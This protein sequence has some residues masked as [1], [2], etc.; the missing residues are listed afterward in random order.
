[1]HYSLEVCEAFLTALRRLQ[2]GISG[3]AVVI[4]VD[5]RAGSG[6]TIFSHLLADTLGRL[7]G[8]VLR[9]RFDAF[10]L[11]GQEFEDLVAALP[12]LAVSAPAPGDYDYAWQL[13]RERLLARL[14][15]GTAADP[16]LRRLVAAC[17]ADDAAA[18]PDAAD[19]VILEGTTCLRREL[20]ASYDLSLLLRLDPQV[21]LR[22][23]LAREQ[24]QGADYFVNIWRPL[25]ARYFEEH[26]PEAAADFV[27]D[28]LLARSAFLLSTGV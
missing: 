19:W 18:D 22:Q 2:A 20:R 16:E 21:C 26:Q 3:R 27:I 10:W 28:T 11:F 7:G 9:L 4:G 15:A 13:C 25:E 17:C 6:K 5:G 1:M 14:R 8:K 23:W 12:E 24:G